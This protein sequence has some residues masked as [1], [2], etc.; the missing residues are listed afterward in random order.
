MRGD[1]IESCTLRCGFRWIRI[2]VEDFVNLKGEMGI[3]MLRR[4]H[5][6]KSVLVCGPR[7]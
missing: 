4:N 5:V 7:R 6:R 3:G 1:A 2:D